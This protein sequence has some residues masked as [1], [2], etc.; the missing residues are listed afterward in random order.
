MRHA[1]PR[2]LLGVLVGAALVGIG[3]SAFAA[4]DEATGSGGAG[5]TSS[6]STGSTTSG[7]TGS[8][9][10]GSS[11]S[12]GMCIA[13]GQT[14]ADANTCTAQCCSGKFHD[15]D[16]AGVLTCAD[17][18]LSAGEVCGDPNLCATDCCSGT[19]V[20]DDAGPLTCT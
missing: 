5:S 20:A 13:A 17:T 4:C 14:C 3:A 16:D 2:P 12:T 8:S 11:S 6:A 15:G 9:T 18:C 7:A 1:R 19:F 10:S